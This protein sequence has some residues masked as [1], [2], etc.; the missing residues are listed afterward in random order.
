LQVIPYIKDGK[1]AEKASH[2]IIIADHQKGRE[3]LSI[4]FHNQIAGH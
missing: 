2:V 4:L 3:K 1:I